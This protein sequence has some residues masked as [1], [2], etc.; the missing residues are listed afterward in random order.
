MKKVIRFALISFVSFS[1][2]TGC[3]LIQNNPDDAKESEKEQEK[4]KTS[5]ESE[6]QTEAEKKNI[7]QSED[8]EENLAA[9]LKEKEPGI[10]FKRIYPSYYSVPPSSTGGVWYYTK[11]EHDGNLRRLGK[12]DREDMIHIQLADPKYYGYVLVPKMIEKKEGEVVRIVVQLHKEN[13]VKNHQPA[14][15]FMKV[16]RGSFNPKVVRFEVRTEGGEALHPH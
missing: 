9:A 16:P 8:T 7:D 6:Q 4:Q 11:E 1:L 5:V 12:W 14:R 2:L 13:L 3:S 10:P 15:A